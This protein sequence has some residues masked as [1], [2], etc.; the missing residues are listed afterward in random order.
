MAAAAGG[1][2]WDFF[3]GHASN[4]R[5]VVVRSRLRE[6]SLRGL[7]DLL[8]VVRVRCSLTARQV[9][10][11]G[12][13][14]S[15]RALDEWEQ[16]IL[17]ELQAMRA[18]AYHLAVVTGDGSREHFFAAPDCEDL[19][20]AIRATQKERPFKLG[21]NK[22]A[23]SIDRLLDSLTLLKAVPAQAPPERVE[24]N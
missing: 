19:I 3:R 10:P 13:P 7:A 22:V 14:L 1:R 6:E 16:E 5:V 8:G 15:T 18:Q 12:M 2:T 21:L 23:G 4:G 17:T 9:N 11:E 24:S 20:T